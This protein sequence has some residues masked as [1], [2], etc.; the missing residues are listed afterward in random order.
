MK[1]NHSDS[2]PYP[3]KRKYGGAF[4]S[5]KNCMEGTKGMGKFMGDV[6]DGK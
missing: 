1:I 3:K 2:S 4:F 6:L 5:K